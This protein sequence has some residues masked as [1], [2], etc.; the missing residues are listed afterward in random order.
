MLYNQSSITLILNQVKICNYIIFLNYY[1]LIEYIFLQFTI[2][3]IKTLMDKNEKEMFDHVFSP[4]FIDYMCEITHNIVIIIYYKTTHILND[5]I[6]RF[7][8]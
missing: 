3:Y 2:I 4:Y 1:L 8:I 6:V 7:I 5:Y